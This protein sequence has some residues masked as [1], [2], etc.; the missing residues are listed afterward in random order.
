M[1][2]V[3]FSMIILP[4]TMIPPILLYHCPNLN[5]LFI[6]AALMSALW[7]GATYYIHIFSKRYNTKFDVVEKIDETEEGENT[8]SD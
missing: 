1:A 6:V 4:A 5:I 7:R 3:C 8:K 2:F